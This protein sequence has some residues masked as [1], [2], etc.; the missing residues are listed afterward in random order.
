MDRIVVQGGSKLEGTVE[1]SGSK[2]SCLK[3]LFATILTKD[4]VTLTRVPDLMDVKTSLALLK[5]FGAEINR[6]ENSVQLKIEKL[7]STKAPYELVRTM[8]ASILCLGPLLARVGEAQVSLP[9]G[10]AIGT[11]PV[12][13]HLWG[14]ER[15]GASFELRGGYIFGTA[16]K[17]L[18]GN[19]IEFDFPSVGAT[20]N[21]MMAA[22]LADGTTTIKNAAREP[23]IG[24]LAKFLRLLGADI[25]GDGS[26][27][28]VV[29]GKKELHG[30]SMEVM[31]DRIEAGTLLLAGIITN[32]NVEV[33][34]MESGCLDAFFSALKQTG[35]LVDERAG[36]TLVSP[37]SN[38][39]PIQIETAPFPGF[40]T[41]LQAQFMAFLAQIEGESTIDE[42]IFEN[43]FMHVPELSRMGA[44][45]SVSG[46]K[47]L[48]QGNKNCYRGATVMA[49]DL[50]AS[51]SLV[52]A[53]LAAKGETRIR[54]IYHLDRG[55]ERLGQK[56]NSLGANIRREKDNA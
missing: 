36:S 15:M 44:K 12:D 22:T 35:V 47:A 54:R 48:I 5:N 34:G 53:A 24:D 37:G 52:L 33:K 23:E 19:E 6:K 2:N 29:Q 26:S 16:P 3:A 41:D 10:C 51:A 31:F 14:L 38:Y 20:E 4:E 40:P 39:K 45:I 8:R 25:T 7:S 55:Y 27:T 9:G 13:F 32:G 43:R 46:S 11:R 18:K 28:I 17:G 30:A 50:R 1:V 49:T 56:L 21:I 42:K